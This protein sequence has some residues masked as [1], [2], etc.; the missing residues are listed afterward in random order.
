VREVPLLSEGFDALK[1]IDAE[2]GLAFDDWDLQ[3]YYKLFSC[4]LRSV[5]SVIASMPACMR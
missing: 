1:A 3:Y 5:Q 4:A 2:L